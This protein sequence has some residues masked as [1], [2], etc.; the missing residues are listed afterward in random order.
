METNHV[1]DKTVIETMVREILL[2]TLQGHTAQPLYHVSPN[3]IIGV[4]VPQIKTVEQDR[5]NTGKA[6]DVVYTKD[7]FTLSESPRLG[8]GIMEMQQT[9][10]HWHLS[11]DEIDFVIEG[12]LQIKDGDT[13]ISAKP[14]ELIYI[15][16]NS[17]IQFCVPQTARFLYVTY[18]ANWSELL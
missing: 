17:D 3:G 8:A 7:L 9:S 16:K 6:E 11:Y 4:Q 14:G 12:E 1:L 10:F 18:P 15:P 2:Q 5:M 13:T